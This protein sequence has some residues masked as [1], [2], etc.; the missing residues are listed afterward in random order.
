[1]ILVWNDASTYSGGNPPRLY[2]KGD[3]VPEYIFPPNILRMFLSN[4]RLVYVEAPRIPRIKLSITVMAH[5]ARQQNFEYLQERLGIPITKFSIDQNNN[6]IEN[7]KNAWLLHDKDA[8]FAVTVQDDAIVC[9]NFKERAERFITE[10]ESERIARKEKPYGYNFFV[11]SLPDPVKMREYENQGYSLEARNR[12]GVAICLPTNQ[13]ENMLRCYSTLTDRH[14]DE[15]IGQWMQRNGFKACFPIPSLIDHDD[16][17]ISLAGNNGL[18]RQAYKFID[19][20]K[21]IIPKMIHQL[22]IGPRPAP[23]KWMRTWREKN[24]DFLYRLWTEKEIVSEKWINQKQIDYYMSRG[25]WHGVKDVC[26]YEILYNHGGVFADADS[27]CLN[28]IAELFTDEFDAYSVWENEKARPGLISPL[29]AAV[30][31]SKFAKELIDKISSHDMSIDDEP[32]RVSGNKMVGEMYKKTIQP[33][34]IFPS[35]YL[36]P[37]HFTGEKY[38]GPD[39]IYARHAWG[40]TLDKYHEGV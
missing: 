31:G 36:I 37:E 5:P 30:K 24:P 21:F 34:K 17:K 26:Q 9:N 18:M 23:V 39:K 25:I 19:N 8:D 13:I 14:D 33:V 1:M 28:P 12:G 15:R 40:T 22:W 11:R 32:W 7:C 2:E 3:Q 35:H 16:H 20:E 29:F 4:G 6:L 38:T 27:I 10:R